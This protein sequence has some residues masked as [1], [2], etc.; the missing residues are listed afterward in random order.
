VLAFLNLPRAA[1]DVRCM[2]PNRIAS[3]R[4]PARRTWKLV[5]VVVAGAVAT[6]VSAA[7]LVAGP[8][9]RD[10]IDRTIT[11]QKVESGQLVNK[12]AIEHQVAPLSAAQMREL[13]QGYEPE[14]RGAVDRANSARLAAYRT[15]DII[16]MTCI[17]DKLLQMRTV[18]SIAEPRLAALR[19]GE[20]TEELQMRGQFSIVHQAWERVKALSAEVDICTGE[21]AD[22]KPLD[23]AGA[24]EPNPNEDFDPGR[25]PAQ[26]VGD[27]RPPEASSY[28]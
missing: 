25:P 10:A 18:I 12:D 27:D 21:A 2:R 9:D 23:Y 26:I 22:T 17:E 11:Q 15:R 5:A 13:T 6:A 1:A 14:M 24:G 3:K 4:P 16:R 8:D 7:Q 28:R 19:L 20:T